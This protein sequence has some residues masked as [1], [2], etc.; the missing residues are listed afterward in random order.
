VLWVTEGPFDWLTL[1]AW[2]VPAVALVGTRVRRELM[3]ELSS[4]PSLV[5]CFDDDSAG[6][7]GADVLEAA[8][9][10]AA[11]RCP[12]FGVAKDVNELAQQPDGERLFR[13]HARRVQ[14]MLARAA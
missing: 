6:G 9:G 1:R 14:Q 5:L 11:V 12:A 10:S 3:G 2:G 8:V 13:A 7:A 4:I